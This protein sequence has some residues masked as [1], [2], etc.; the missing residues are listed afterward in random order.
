MLRK[1][2]ICTM[3][4][5]IAACCFFPP[6]YEHLDK[7][8]YQYSY[9]IDYPLLMLRIAGTVAAAGAVLALFRPVAPEDKIEQQEA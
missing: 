5:I 7:N 4:T 2:I 1:T 9:G 8:T 6:R 3:F